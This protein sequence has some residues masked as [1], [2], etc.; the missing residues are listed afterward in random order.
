VTVFSAHDIDLVPPLVLAQATRLGSDIALPLSA[1]DHPFLPFANSRHAD[2]TLQQVLQDIS[3]IAATPKRLKLGLTGDGQ[4][5]DPPGGVRRVHT[6]GLERA[7]HM[8]FPHRPTDLMPQD[9]ERVPLPYQLSLFAVLPS[10][11][12]CSPFLT[13]HLDFFLVSL[14]LS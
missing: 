3:T 11:L 1:H 6:L 10:S 7:Q 13:L 9:H 14:F 12:L 5:F 2:A 8:L 4:D